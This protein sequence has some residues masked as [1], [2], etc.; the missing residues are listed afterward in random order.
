MIDS[1]EKGHLRRGVSL[2]SRDTNQMEL[3]N[4]VIPHFPALWTSNTISK[5]SGREYCMHMV[6]DPAD[7]EN[8]KRNF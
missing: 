3:S 4:C 7:A 5:S 6:N 1:A 2:V 8:L